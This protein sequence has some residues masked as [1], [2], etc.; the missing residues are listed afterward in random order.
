MATTI[1][2]NPDTLEELVPIT[3]RDQTI[4]LP[5]DLPFIVVRDHWEKHGTEGI[6]TSIKIPISEEE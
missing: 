6:N 1:L 2:R 4:Y 5:K 3:I